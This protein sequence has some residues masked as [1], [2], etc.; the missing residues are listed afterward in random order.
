[1]VRICFSDVKQKI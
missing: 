1:L